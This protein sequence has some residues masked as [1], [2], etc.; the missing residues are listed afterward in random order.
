MSSKKV[1]SRKKHVSTAI[2]GAMVASFMVPAAIPAVQGAGSFSDVSS[3]AFYAGAV[4]DLASKGIIGGYSNG[5]FQPNKQVTRAEAAKILA[6]DLGLTT[7]KGAATSFSDVKG[8]DWFFQ[9][10]T[11]LAEA[12]GINGYKDGAFQPNKTITRAEMASLIVKAYDLKADESATTPFTDVPTNSWYAGAVK[13]LYANKVTTGK[14]SVNTFAPNDSVTRG[15]MAVF[16]QRAS[17]LKLG[18]T[19]V[20]AGDV[21]EE[22]TASTV[23]IGGTTFTVSDSVKGLLGEHN[24]AILKG[25]KIEF[26]ET[27]GVISKVNTIQLNTAGSSSDTEFA[28]NLVLDGKGNSIG[29]LVINANYITVKNVTVLGNLTITEKLQ[30]DF[31]SE[32]LIVKGKTMIEG[33]DD[34][35]VVFKEGSLQS[36]ELAK[37]GVHFEVT[38]STSVKEII[39]YKNAKISSV[40]S[41]GKIIVKEKGIKLSFGAGIKVDNIE[42]P[43]GVDLKDVV[44][45]SGDRKNITNINGKSNNEHSSS[46]LSSNSG[47]SGSSDNNNDDNDKDPE[48]VQ[49]QPLLAANISIANAIGE[50]DT[51]TVKAVDANSTI[52]VYTS[53]SENRIIKSAIAENSTVTLRG[54]NLGASA[55]SVWITVQKPGQLESARTKVDFVAELVGASGLA[56]SKSTLALAPTQSNTL[57]ASINVTGVNQSDVIFTWESLDKNIA[58]VDNNGAVTALKAGKVLIKVTATL[59]DNS[60]ITSTCEVTVYEERAL[61]LTAGQE[62]ALGTVKDAPVKVASKIKLDDSPDAKE[63]NVAIGLPEVP[64][65]ATLTVSPLPAEI[66]APPKDAPFIALDIAISGFSKNEQF[67][68]E[69][70]I[71]EGLNEE[72]PGAYHYNSATGIWEYREGAI[73]NGKFVFNTNF[74]PVSIGKRVPAPLDLTVTQQTTADTISF[75]LQW[76]GGKDVTYYKVFNGNEVVDARV[77][78]TSVTISDLE[79]G[80]YYFYVRAYREEGG[81]AEGTKATFESAI[82]NVVPIKVG[83]ETDDT[84]YISDFSID[85]RNLVLDEGTSDK[86][87]VITTPYDATEPLSWGST[88]P[89]VASVDQKGTITAVAPGTT[90][91]YVHPLNNPSAR[92]EIIVVVQ[93]EEKFAV[94][95]T[96]VDMVSAPG[97]QSN[98]VGLEAIFKPNAKIDKLDVV[99]AFDTTGSMSGAIDAAKANAI[100]IMNQIRSKVSDAQF[101]VVSFEDYSGYTSENGYWGTY[102]GPDDDPYMLD[103]AVTDNPALIQQAIDKLYAD[104]GADG[105]ESYT[106]ALYE[107]SDQTPRIDSVRWRSDSKKLIVLF[108]D[109]PTHD[110]TFAGNNYGED[111]GRDGIGKTADDLRFVDVVNSLRDQGIIVLAVDSYDGNNATLKGMSI[112]YLPSEADTW[113]G[114][115]GTNGKYVLLYNSSLPVIVDDFVK[116]QVKVIH[117][118]KVVAPEE[119]KDWVTTDPIELRNIPLP[120]G[121]SSEDI[122]NK[123]DLFIK[124]PVDTPAGEYEFQVAVYADGVELGTTL[125]RVTVDE[126]RVAKPTPSLLTQKVPNGAKVTLSAIATADV[127][128]YTTDGSEPTVSSPIFTTGDTIT[129]TGDTVVKAIAVR[130][131]GETAKISDVMVKHYSVLILNKPI[132]SLPAGEVRRGASVELEANDVGAEIYYTIDGTEP[133]EE[134]T[135]YGS[136]LI[137]NED[138]TLKAISLVTSDI[139]GEKFITKSDIST[140]DYTVSTKS[141][142]DELD[143]FLVG[144]IDLE[145]NLFDGLAEIEVSDPDTENVVEFEVDDFTDF[146]GIEVSS[147]TTVDS[148][149]VELNGSVIPEEDLASQVIQSGDTL[150]VTVNAEDGYS[151]RYYKVKF[152]E[153]F[154]LKSISL[155]DEGT[156][157]VLTTGDSVQFTFS[158]TIPE[159]LY[160]GLPTGNI[161]VSLEANPDTTTPDSI[162]FYVREGEEQHTFELLTVQGADIVSNGDV[163]YSSTISIIDNKLL[164]RLEELVDGDGENLN[165]VDS[166]A[167]IIE[168][169]EERY[170]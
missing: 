70:D 32:K 122:V 139:Y 118:I 157:G 115:E 138:T 35:T 88:N 84:I 148:I 39:V 105:P 17:Q 76:Q 11:A 127:I 34:N 12:G 72:D 98:A 170:E 59:P 104:N 55:G 22:V 74:S 2:T 113:E 60:K 109:A 99:F 23:V 53:A 14:G 65:E 67:R 5:T 57:T 62:A 164:F 114:T 108:G 110:L 31:F 54:L 152:V 159:E 160:E 120:E 116:E 145:N 69:L 94:T 71:P 16:V 95:P 24:A 119:Y 128:H 169:N 1:N 42:L 43:D 29:E 27:N 123:L 141:S 101:G 103:Q 149:I 132:A 96:E 90:T 83:G 45:S 111:P 137:I 100:D 25:A 144:G 129:I 151:S 86:I 4:N 20:V 155:I 66:P 165:I 9:P 166:D 41:V 30:N 112:G 18:T 163:V 6:F 102:G 133:S 135:K 82:S 75:V 3:D 56:L 15:E 37:E 89:F 142:Y 85:R 92:K 40:K 121:S 36:V 38:G 68:V 49:T 46:S 8:S 124:P 150:L 107:L 7:N 13:A 134:S 168:F 167:V 73:E 10:V 117:S 51:V 143:T 87:N 140:F 91:I 21:I 58:T 61:N 146:K 131:E 19:P 81:A 44:T 156:E 161:F 130:G 77:E 97:E 153:S 63:V 26:E 28:N 158:K 125:V 64:A 147:F 79:N 48:L 93:G 47:S 136:P 80:M 162:R 50:N 154:I 126:S 33:G 52:R 78:D 106:R